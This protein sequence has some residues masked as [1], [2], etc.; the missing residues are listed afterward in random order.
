LWADQYDRDFAELYLVEDAVVNE[1]SKQ[2]R[3]SV[4]TENAQL[5]NCHTKNAEAYQLYLRGR[6]WF[7]SRT[8]EGFR[9]SID[10]FKNAIKADSQYGLP[11][12]Y[13][14]ITGWFRLKRVSQKL[15]QQPRRRW[16]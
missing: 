15:V 16:T 10:Y 2:L 14:D 9:K 3:L 1:V 7:E 13:Q 8:P 4:G 12:I 5:N 6:H 11:S